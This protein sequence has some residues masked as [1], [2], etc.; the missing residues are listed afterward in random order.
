MLQP[1]KVDKL[2][3]LFSFV[4]YYLLT[5]VP[6]NDDSALEEPFFQFA[7]GAHRED[8]WRWLEA[9]DAQFSVA[10]APRSKAA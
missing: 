1:G 2:A 7:A 5:D 4:L 8:V 6:V 3:A 9:R 10:T